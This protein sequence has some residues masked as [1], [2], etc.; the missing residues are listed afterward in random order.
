MVVTEH[1][2][3]AVVDLVT[4]VAAVRNTAILTRVTVEITAFPI[5]RI[6]VLI[7]IQKIIAMERHRLIENV[8]RHEDVHRDEEGDE[9]TYEV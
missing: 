4:V 9:G 7:R 3:H 6:Y 1:A 2:I 8:K 5:S